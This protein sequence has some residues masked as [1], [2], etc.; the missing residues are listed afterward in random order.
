MAARATGEVASPVI[1]ATL[2][3]VAV[4]LPTT[5]NPTSGMLIF[6]PQDQII[7]LDMTT[8]DGLKLVISGGVVAPPYSSGIEPH[9][10]KPDSEEPALQ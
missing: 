9:E 3:T 4:F 1:P 5:P 10:E 8:E 6:V 7:H 2:T